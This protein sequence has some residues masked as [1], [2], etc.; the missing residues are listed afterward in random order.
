MDNVSETTFISQTGTSLTYSSDTNSHLQV[1]KNGVKLV[2]TTDFTSNTTTI[3]LNDTLDTADIVQVVEFDPTAFVAADG[4]ATDA[5]HADYSDMRL[6]ENLNLWTHNEDIY[7]VNTYTYYW[8][9]KDRFHDRQEVG[10]VAQELE[11]HVP[12]VVVKNAEGERMVDY[13]KMTAV[14]LSLVKEQKDEIE[15][16]KTILLKNGI[17]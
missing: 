7:N 5:A 3:T 13:G 4:T 17:E 8:Q 2:P 14:L 6:K 10:F 12:Q 16:L 9:D 15:N 1:F 11:Q